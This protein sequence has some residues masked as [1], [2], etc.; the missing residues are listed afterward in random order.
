MLFQ[1]GEAFSNLGVTK[2]S[3]N[4]NKQSVVENG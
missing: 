1:T 2:M 4:N 3:Y